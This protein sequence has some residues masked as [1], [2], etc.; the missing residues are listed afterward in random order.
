MKA[1]GNFIAPPTSDPDCF[2]A[3]NVPDP[4]P[5]G[6][7][8]LVRVRAVSVNPVDTG[9]RKNVTPGQTEPRIVGWDASGVVEAVGD[10]AT[11]FK[12][13]DTV[14]YAG[15][16]IRPGCN[17]ELHL[18]D[19]R[20]VGHKPASLSHEQA[21][22]MPLTTLTAWEALFTRMAIAPAPGGRNDQRTLLVI[23]GAGGVG[24]IA[25]Q[26]AKRV[27]GMRVIATASRPESVDW[28]R[29]MGAD[30]VID[31]RHPLKDGLGA[32]GVGAVSNVLCCSHFGEY[33]AQL[34]GIVEAFGFVCTIIGTNDGTINIGGFFDK[35]IAVGFELMYTR[36]THQTPDMQAQ[37]D[38]LN[39]AARLLDAG[40][41]RCTHTE[42]FGPLTAE[43]LRRA[44]E[45]VETRAMIGKLSLSGI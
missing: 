3:L 9:M 5:A 30:H 10:A 18:V 25:I 37:H 17:S 35:S 2:I 19:E 15:S 43:N 22:A 26:L 29:A 40:V 16:I 24:S 45:R 1:I 11:L 34:P 44:H 12:P 13:G 31:H 7:D 32:I 28:C 38:I 27:A 33:V 21:A 14:Y 42:S 41:L 36:S 6:R 20:I 4:K 39:E 8:L 23:G